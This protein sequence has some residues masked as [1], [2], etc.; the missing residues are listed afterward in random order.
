MKQYITGIKEHFSNKW[1]LLVILLLGVLICSKMILTDKIPIAVG[2]SVVPFILVALVI[3]INR[4]KIL[5]TIVFAVNYII[6]GLNRY[7]SFPIPISVIMDGIYMV[8][9]AILVVYSIKRTES[10]HR[11]FNAMTGIYLVWVIYCLIEAF[12]DT[13]GTG[14]AF[15]PWFRE[16]RPMAF[17]ILYIIIIYALLFNKIKD[18]KW[19]M[20]LWGIFILLATAKGYW[21]RNHGFDRY[22][23]A[24]LMAGG[25][26]THFISTGIRYFSFFSDAANYG[27]NMAACMVIYSICTLYTKKKFEKIYCILITLASGYGMLI[28]GTRSAMMVALIGYVLFT[29]LSKNWKYF[30]LAIGVVIFSIVFFKFTTLGESNRLIHRMRTA[31]NPQDA[32]LQVRLQN[33]K[34][35]KAYMREAPWGIGIG[36]DGSNIPTTNKYWVVSITPPDS[37]L[38]YI[39]IRTGIIGLIVF[40]TVIISLI[41]MECYIVMFKIKHKELR[42]LL[43]AFTCAGACMLIAGYGN[44]ILTQYPNS[45]LFFGAQTL[46]FMGTYFDKQLTLE[47]EQQQSGKKTESNELPA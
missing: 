24:W 23:M 12:N 46:V 10:W 37:T 11:V 35:I 39:W 29:L 28:S 42:G 16:V 2:I 30:T 8:T 14:F 31:F 45:L 4:P 5:F 15:T 41:L 25:A 32:S 38:V 44:N 43:T 27:S 33:Q 13:T 34:A 21:Q 47:E 17:H 36:R 40:L 7:V 26:R 22:E 3:F 19:L 6:M 9:I 18:I 20:F 1:G